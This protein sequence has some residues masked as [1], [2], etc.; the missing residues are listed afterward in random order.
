MR[1]DLI[2]TDVIM[3]RMNGSEMT[4]RLRQLPDFAKTPIIASSASLSQVE[5]QDA[6]DAGCNSFF[7]KQI[8]F[9]GLLSELQRHL[10][11]QWIYETAPELGDPAIGV[12][13][14]A[15]LV[16]PSPEEL[17]TLYQAAKDGF[18]SDVQQEA[19][20]LKQLNPQYMPFANKL[21]ELSQRFDDEGIL[22]LLEPYVS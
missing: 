20:R 10:E 7:P 16:I 1:P 11:L 12:A 4:R 5:M 18:M 21:L 13:S 19:N 17:S 14:S 22:S 6:I 2:L 9:T 15:D 8:E 3:S